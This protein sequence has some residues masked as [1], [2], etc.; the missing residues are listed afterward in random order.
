MV[1]LRRAREGNVVCVQCETCRGRVGCVWE[2]RPLAID[3]STRANLRRHLASGRY[4]G[5]LDSS[6]ALLI[7]ATFFRVRTGGLA[8]FIRYIK[9]FASC[10]AATGTNNV[11]ARPNV[12]CLPM[13]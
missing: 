2:S 12:T 4:L 8:V 9:H 7:G 5:T 6:A 10:S 1:W 11:H 3:G 13:L